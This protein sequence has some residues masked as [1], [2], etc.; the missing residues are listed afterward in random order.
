MRWLSWRCALSVRTA[1]YVYSG[2]GD[3]IA[4]R[5]HDA[6]AGRA[7]VSKAAKL[8]CVAR[9]FAGG[10]AALPRHLRQRAPKGLPPASL[11]YSDELGLD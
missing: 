6:W 8:A 3:V 10:L 4:A 2:I 11:P 1:R 9:A 7:Y 5:D